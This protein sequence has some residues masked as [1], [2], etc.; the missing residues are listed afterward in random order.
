MTLYLWGT[1]QQHCTVKAIYRYAKMHLAD[2]FPQLPSYQAFCKRVAFLAPAFE[3]YCAMQVERAPEPEGVH[4][5]IDAMPVQVARAHRSGRARAAKG[6]CGKTYCASR[7]EWYYGVKLHVLAS[8]RHKTLPVPRVALIT[9]A[10]EP[11]LGTAKHIFS[12]LGVYGCSLLADRAYVD[13]AWAEHLVLH[14]EVSLL[15]PRKR[16]SSVP[17]W[18]RSGDA[19]STALC[20]ARQPIE[21]FFNWINQ[22]ARIQS[23]SHVRSELGL[24]AHIFGKFAAALRALF[25]P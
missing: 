2:W 14:N 15:H 5:V 1:E 20:A 22:K 4:A 24:R 6:L 13:K 10:N 17:E 3:V 21:V 11:D 7:D 18:S 8:L 19:L 9:P 25:N 12:A 16:V 23:A